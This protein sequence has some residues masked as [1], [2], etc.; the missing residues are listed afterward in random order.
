MINRI[1]NRLCRKEGAFA[2]AIFV[3]EQL[4]LDAFDEAHLLFQLPIK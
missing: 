4:T 2:T 3:N 1:I